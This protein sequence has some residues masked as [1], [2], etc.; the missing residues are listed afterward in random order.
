MEEPL[1]GAEV[2]PPLL[3]ELVKQEGVSQCYLMEDALGMSNR[4][5]GGMGGSFMN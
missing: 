1:V 2:Q 5:S 4:P 3:E